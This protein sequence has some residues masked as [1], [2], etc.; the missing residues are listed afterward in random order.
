MDEPQKHHA[1]YKK[2][3]TKEHI[4][5]MYFMY[6]HVFIRNVENRQLYRSRSRLVMPGGVGSVGPL[7]SLRYLSGVLKMS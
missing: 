2:P 3:V 5:C 4:L 1:E 7:M 6:V